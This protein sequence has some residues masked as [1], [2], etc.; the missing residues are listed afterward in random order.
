MTALRRSAPLDNRRGHETSEPFRIAGTA[1][2]AW[3]TWHGPPRTARGDAR[4]RRDRCSRQLFDRI[5]VRGGDA[6]IHVSSRSTPTGEPKPSRATWPSTSTPHSGTR[7]DHEEIP[8]TASRTVLPDHA[9]WRRERRR[10]TAHGTAR[11]CTSLVNG[12]PRGAV[13][14]NRRKLRRAE[15]ALTVYRTVFPTRQIDPDPAALAVGHS[16]VVLSGPPRTLRV[17][18]VREWPR[19]VPPRARSE[20]HGVQAQRLVDSVDVP[21]C[22]EWSVHHCRSV[23]RPG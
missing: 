5:P 3:G 8:S 23:A 12:D 6:L 16:H 19:G 17:L 4:G 7:A 13:P 21:P 1:K 22:R 2:R 14:Q 9:R 15:R 11:K 18:D 20:Q 10:S